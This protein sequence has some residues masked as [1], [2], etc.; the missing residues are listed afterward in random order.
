MTPET[1]EEVRDSFRAVAQISDAAADIFYS[2]LF[3]RDPSLR[4]MFPMDLASQKKKL[5]QALAMA[6]GTLDRPDDLL[7]RLRDLGARHADYGVTDAHY[8][9]VGAALLETLA[10]GLGDRFT[11]AC[12]AAWSQVYGV[13]AST[14]QAGAAQRAAA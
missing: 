10:V 8:Q 14:M 1:I 9:T 13:V 11:P 6:V 3:A 4:P 5:I 12:R 7:P 2:D